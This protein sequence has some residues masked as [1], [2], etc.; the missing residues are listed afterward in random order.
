MKKMNLIK[1]IVATGTV[2]ALS[3]AMLAG[4]ALA[5]AFVT[6][7][8]GIWYDNGD[9]TFPASVWKWIDADGDGKYQCFAFDENGYVYVNATTPDGFT[10]TGDGSW[11]QNG[12]QVVR[13]TLENLSDSAIVSKT[14]NSVK[15][16][17][18]SSIGTKSSSNSTTSVSSAGDTIKDTTMT[19]G[20]LTQ[21][22]ISASDI[23]TAKHSVKRSVQSAA[24]SEVKYSGNE[25]DMSLTSYDTFGPSVPEGAET[26]TLAP[27]TDNTTVNVAGPDGTIDNGSEN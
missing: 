19:V 16:Q 5:G 9:G 17:T 14:V 3:V 20:H 27:L 15:S 8:K 24:G 4:T 10:T 26:S 7:E 1:K 18:N 6:N 23:V 22:H 25:P 2:A 21:T 11:V 12:A 13:T